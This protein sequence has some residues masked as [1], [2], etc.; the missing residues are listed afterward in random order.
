[1]GRSV[2]GSGRGADVAGEGVWRASAGPGTGRERK[3]WR[4]MAGAG[5]EGEE[6]GA[7]RS[8]GGTGEGVCG[9]GS[10]AMAVETTRWGKG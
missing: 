1:M 4:L 2:C 8:V 5:A 3:G 10:G 6:R 9:R 7:G